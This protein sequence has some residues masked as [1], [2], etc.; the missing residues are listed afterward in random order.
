MNLS[1]WFHEKMRMYRTK[2]YLSKYHS[3]LTRQTI[4]GSKRKR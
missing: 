3:W 2:K 4:K 1:H